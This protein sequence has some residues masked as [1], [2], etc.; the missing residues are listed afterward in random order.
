MPIKSLTARVLLLTTLWSAVALVVIGLVIS[1][2]YRKS[3]ERG[4]QDLLRAQLYNVINS[5]TIGDQG[6]LAGSP[7]LGDLRFAQPK[8]GWYWMVE[9]LGTYTAAPAGLAVA[10]IGQPAGAVGDRGAVRQELRA[11]LHRHGFLRQ[12]CPGGRD[13]G[14]ARHRRPR[15]AIPRHRQ[16]RRH[17]G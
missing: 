10:R 14:R 13:R 15:R 16:Y 17:R 5:V 11:L 3:A 6:A 1:T 2:L 7:Q 8:T 4:F 9:P 12:S